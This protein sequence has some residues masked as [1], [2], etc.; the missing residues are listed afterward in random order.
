[1]ATSTIRNCCNCCNC[2]SDRHSDYY[3]GMQGNSLQH[4]LSDGPRLVL[5]IW[6]YRFLMGLLYPSY[7]V[8]SA[9]RT[10]YCSCW[11]SD[12]DSI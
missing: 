2:C 12:I 10:G 1:M 4:S 6:P 9:L 7:F 11:L 3:H 5:C 8:P